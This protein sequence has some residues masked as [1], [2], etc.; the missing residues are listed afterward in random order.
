[1][2]K[3]IVNAVNLSLN[4]KY[5]PLVYL[6]ALSSWATGFCFTF[7]DFMPDVQNT[8][9]YKHGIFLGLT[10]WG[11]LLFVA[12]SMLIVGLLGNLQLFIKVGAFIGF[13]LWLFGSLTYLLNG[14]YYA[15][16]AGGML[17][18]LALGFIYLR[19]SQGDLRKL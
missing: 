12:M 4:T 6:F 19:N 5:S 17:H 9:L 16:V 3:R 13:V 18:M 11:G 1:M 10:L 7:L 2:Q 14:F 15:L 8:L